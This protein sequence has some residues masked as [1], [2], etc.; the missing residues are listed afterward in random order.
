MKTFPT[1][2]FLEVKVLVSQGGSIGDESSI[3]EINLFCSL[4]LKF[5]TYDRNLCD[6]FDNYFVCR[7]KGVG[8]VKGK[9]DE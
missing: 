9:D 6:E 3:C 4:C 8:G 7:E 2:F 5:H 1:T